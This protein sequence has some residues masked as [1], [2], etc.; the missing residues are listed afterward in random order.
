MERIVLATDFGDASGEALR[1]A[2]ALAQ[3]SGA[4]LELV[5]VMADPS[6]EPRHARARLEALACPYRSLPLD[7]AIAV[8]VG[9]VAHQLLEHLTSAHADLVVIGIANAE[10]AQLPSI[11]LIA[12]RLLRKTPCPVLAVP[13]I[14]VESPDK[15]RTPTAPWPRNILVATDFSEPARAALPHA[16]KLAEQTDGVLQILHVND[17]LWNEGSDGS[18][19]HG[20]AQ[21]IEDARRH[22]EEEI[23]GEQAR[24]PSHRPTYPLLA[25][26]E[27]AR[28]ILACADRIAADVIV[29]GTH[30]RSQ[31][32]RFLLGSV[33][34]EVLEHAVRPV[35]VTRPGD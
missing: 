9:S 34:Q 16:W 22:L 23:A 31:V 17:T 7:I 12:E 27:P 28:E 10:H 20:H 29:M 3:T 35:L 2:V 11:G 26:G 13:A 5:H 21:A 4:K 19:G 24:T 18:P 8:H 25:S 32:G 33:T 14:R 1:Y 15:P 6:E 30:G